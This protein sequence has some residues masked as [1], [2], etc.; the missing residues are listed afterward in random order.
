VVV[1]AIMK[2]TIA[3]IG[4]RVICRN[5]SPVL[6]ACQAFIRIAITAI[7]YG[8]VVKRRV[9]TLLFPRPPTTLRKVS[10]SLYLRRFKAYVGKKVVTV[11]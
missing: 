4:G 9:S 7:K 10:S 3:I 6:S 11:P 2:D 5:R 8:G 1:T